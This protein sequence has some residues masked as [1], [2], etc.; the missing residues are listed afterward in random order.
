M[1]KLL[2]IVVFLLSVSACQTVPVTR[3]FPSAPEEL[4]APP[5][6]MVPIPVPDGT[7]PSSET[8]LTE[9]LSGIIDNNTICGENY[10]LLRG[11]QSWYNKTK[12]LYED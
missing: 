3:P 4:L 11:W 9:F 5:K 1:T 10:Y 2:P 6:E 7:N 12:Q 8:R